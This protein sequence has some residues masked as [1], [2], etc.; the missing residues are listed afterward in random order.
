MDSHISYAN[1]FLIAIPTAYQSIYSHS[2]VYL[3]EHSAHGAIGMIINHP[4]PVYLQLMFEQLAIHVSDPIINQKPL[5]FGG[6]VQ[7]E[8]GFVIHRP[9]GHFHASLTMSKDVM[10]TTS[11]DIIRA[12]ATHGGPHDPI[13]TLGYT[14]WQ[15]NQLE[16]E[17][18]N[19]AWL[20]CP[21]SADLLYDVPYEKRWQFAGSILGVQMNQISTQ[22]GHS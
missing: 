16:L 12:I 1:N 11:S 8:R 2:V 10:L 5:L 13:I 20:V 14:G 22:I 19:N 9:S 7:P 6:P 4:M 18:A 3:C 21:F 15:A 17:L